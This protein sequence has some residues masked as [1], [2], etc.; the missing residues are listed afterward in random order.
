MKALINFA[1]NVGTKP[2]LLH[3]VEEINFKQLEK[4]ISLIEKKLGSISSKQITVLGTAFK[5]NT[6]DIRDSIAIELIKK[7]LKKRAKITVYDPKAIKNTKNVF[8][9]KISYGKSIADA[10][11][12]SQCA[13][14]MT[15][16]KQFEALNNKSTKH[17]KRKLIIDCRRILAKKE[18]DVDYHALGIGK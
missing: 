11:S 16:W 4:I 6:D 8:A 15:Q 5:P 9:E 7:L 17:M 10:L 3:A 12:N 14:I 13:I 18:L 2:T 1:N